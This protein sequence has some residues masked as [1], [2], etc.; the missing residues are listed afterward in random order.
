MCGNKQERKSSD[1]VFAEPKTP[2]SVVRREKSIK[3]QD[4]DIIANEI[5]KQLGSL[6]SDYAM[7]HE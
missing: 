7:K 5:K 6:G 3:K 1:G 2:G 4:S